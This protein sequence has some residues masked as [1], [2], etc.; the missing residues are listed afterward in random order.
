MKD[1]KDRILAAAI[2]LFNDR[3]YQQINLADIAY[4][5]SISRGNLAYHFKDKDLILQAIAK[6]MNEEIN[7][8]L[9]L[10]K[11]FPAFS[12][13]QI[14]IKSYHKLQ[15][16][17]QFVFGNATVLHH[18]SIMK[19]MHSWAQGTISGNMEAFAFAI[20][21]GNMKPEL[22]PGMY[23]LLA[24]NTWMVTYYWMT[25]KMVRQVH[26]AEDAERMVWSVVIP[27][28]TERGIESFSKY[29]GNNFLDTLGE[30]FDSLTKDIMVF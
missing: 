12:N 7:Q 3:G 2:E 4:A 19:V 24:I 26:N 9:S 16:N 28:F 15:S 6:R 11:D 30:S 29:F 25:Q 27:H 21:L 8:E 18:E 23:Q 17:Y 22:Y 10:K 20:R 13:L 14:E 5:L 1:T